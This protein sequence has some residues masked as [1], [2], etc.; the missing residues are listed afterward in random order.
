MISVS[1]SFDFCSAHRLYITVPQSHPCSVLHG[2][3][4]IGEVTIGNRQLHE[5]PGMLVEF[6]DMKRAL[7]EVHNVFDHRLVLN[8]VDPLVNVLKG[9]QRITLM[10]GDPVVENMAPA[11]AYGFIANLGLSALTAFQ[12]EAAP[13]FVRI[14]MY[15]T[16]NS[17]AEFEFELGADLLMLSVTDLS[18][19]MAE[20]FVRLVWI[21]S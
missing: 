21:I 15:E 9:T 7:A 4:Y 14:K 5:L 2:H 1:K 18:L 19:R 3:N 8:E 11:W 13:Y 10:K 12:V 17:F 6:S 20:K 16:R